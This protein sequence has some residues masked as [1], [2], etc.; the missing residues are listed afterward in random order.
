LAI[1]GI[2]NADSQHSSPEVCNDQTDHYQTPIA[3]LAGL[4]DAGPA[5]GVSC[6]GRS[7]S[8]HGP[9]AWRGRESVQRVYSARAVFCHQAK[10]IVVLEAVAAFESKG[11]QRGVIHL[12]CPL[13]GLAVARGCPAAGLLE[14]VYQTFK[15]FFVGDDAVHLCGDVCWPICPHGFLAFVGVKATLLR[16]R[17]TRARLQ[18]FRII[19]RLC[20][21]PR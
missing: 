19:F 1:Q 8:P 3:G 6:A 4:T 17:G 18:H 7:R 16:R 11:C 5:C 15:G 20:P 9:P 12:L 14:Q 2:C 10:V 13:V 21:A